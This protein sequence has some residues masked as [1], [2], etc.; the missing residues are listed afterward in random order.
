M[1]T[2]S[3][4]GLAWT[5]ANRALTDQAGVPD[6]I[7]DD[8]GTLRVYYVTWCPQ[9]VHNQTV[10]ALSAD[11][12]Q[13]WS[14][15]P[16]TINGLD[17]GQPSAV[18]P[19]IVRTDDGRWRLYFTS[20]PA[21]P[22]ATPRTYSA[23]SDDGFT[24]ELED[25]YRFY[26][27]GK[28]VLDPSLIQIGDVWHLFAG[29]AVTTP[30]YNWHATSTDGLNFTPQDDFG[31]AGLTM[32]NG[33]AVPGGYRFYGFRNT[34]PQPAIQPPN[35]LSAPQSNGAEILSIFTTDG[36]TWTAEP[37]VRLAPDASATL[38]A[39]GVADPAVALLADGRYIMI[40]VTVIPEYLDSG[41]SPTPTQSPISNLQSPFLLA[42]HACD[43]TA[44][45]CRDPRNHQVY[46]AQSDDGANWSLVP[47]WEP[48]Q[49]SVPDVIRR[50][51][52]IYVYTPGRVRRYRFSTNTWEDPVPMTLTDPEATG[53]YVDPS[54]FVDDQGRLVL[55][56]LLGIVGQDP[57]GCAP[58]ETTC[59]KHF[60]SAI[61]VEGSD[62]TAFVAEPG[63]RVQVTL[64]GP[65][66]ASDPDIFYDGNR[67]V[68]YISRGPS[69]QVY[70]S[71]TLHGSYTL[72]DSLPDG[73]LS[74]AGGIPAGH[75]DPATARY[76]T[77]VHTTQGVI[78]RAIHASLDMPLDESDFTTVLNSSSIGLGAS[79]QVGSPGFAVNTAGANSTPTPT[80]TPTAAPT[81]LPD[82]CVHD[83]NNNAIVDVVDL[84]AT[85]SDLPC[86]VY[87]PVIVANWRRPWP[88]ATP[89]PTATPAA[90]PPGPPPDAEISV[91]V[92]PVT[93]TTYN[94]A[95]ITALE[96]STN[97]Y[98]V[99]LNGSEQPVTLRLTSL[100]EI[101]AAKPEWMFHFFAFLTQSEQRDGII[102]QPGEERT[103]EF[104]LTNEGAGEVD[105]PF[106]FRV[107]ETGDEN[108]ILLNVRSVDGRN[109]A[110]AIARLPLT[111]V[112]TGRVTGENDQPLSDVEVN[113]WF[114]Q[115]RQ[116]WRVPT[117]SSGYY[118]VQ[119]PSIEDI[120]VALGPRPLPYNSLD[121]YLIIEASGYALAYRD[122]IT[123]ARGETVTVDLTLEPVE[124]VVSYQQT[125]ELSTDGAYGYWW[126]LPDGSFSRLAAVQARHPPMLHVPGHFLMTDLS[127]RE[128]WRIS[129]GDE[130][131]GFDVTADGRVAAGCH[132]GVVYLADAEGNLLWQIDVGQMNREVG[133]SPDGAYL[134]TGPYRDQDAA[135]LDA[136]TGAAVWT[137]REPRQWLRASR[138]SPD[139]ERIVAGFGFGQ[140]VMLTGEGTPLWE[141]AIGEFPMVLEIDADYNVYAA[142]KNR[143]LFSFDA[144]GNLR[145]RHRIPDHVVTAGLDNMSA[146]GTSI[147]LGTVGGW[148][149]AFDGTGQIVWRRRLPGSSQGH[150]AFDMTPD[151]KWLVSG[152]DDTLVLYDE[153]GTLEWSY[154][155]DAPV[156]AV[157]ISDDGL[158]IA[159]AQ[160]NNVI[161]I[162]GRE[163]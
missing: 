39:L 49:G 78:G 133:F 53:G 10:V 59:V 77:Y 106:R 40:Y 129:T 139:G 19:D 32:A 51:D 89:T 71:T 159:A 136:A 110:D 20:A 43:T 35:H 146:D 47:D 128:L 48:Y 75:F 25:G 143:E 99:A 55:F 73:Y 132:D 160:E 22:G 158:H 140:L 135:L 60:H 86:H 111:A 46:L 66:S 34:A 57:A 83:I 121:Y 13:T 156:K 33:L 120:Q 6:A 147:V 150:N 3:D 100:T 113:V 96:S 14:Y 134:F 50:G 118:H 28:E 17:A 11:A 68:L 102:L 157:A 153:S 45:D 70:T 119:V 90:T 137:Y 104:M 44:T 155:A 8:E 36:V 18:D 37:G 24:F 29:G 21:S 23:I 7:V 131:W 2:Y 126:V 42:F 72:S 109:V 81:P 114:F 144:A 130:C 1:I 27:E 41:G 9:E 151:G 149:Y 161:R 16:V 61:E 56:Y 145:W 58:G 103:L 87:L 152:S 15:R 94:P 97:L 91:A 115:G 69:V 124:Q 142:G 125:G 4:D 79:Y 163:P 92:G 88:T 116:S 12:G 76:W 52:T 117:D 5:R 63:D 112:I 85:A 31:V 148:L 127:G 154:Q 30:R 26:V 108:T 98:F 64:D 67:Y 65:G 105:L 107:E 82:E 80:P 162:F 141:A 54:L 122:G 38:E 123:P 101:L 138:W 74:H 62:G 84:M 93:I 95:T